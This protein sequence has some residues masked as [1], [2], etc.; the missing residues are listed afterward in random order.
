MIFEG[1]QCIIYLN[2]TFKELVI[3]KLEITYTVRT[4]HNDHYYKM[5]V[6]N[7]LHERKINVNVEVWLY[8]SHFLN[9]LT[10]IVIATS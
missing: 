4:I 5:S 9:D 2:V 10:N 7:P 3:E 1:S 6:E 8:E